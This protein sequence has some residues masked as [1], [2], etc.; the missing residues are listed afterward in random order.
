MTWGGG[1]VSET[2]HPSF[3]IC[4]AQRLARSY[5]THPASQSHSHLQAAWYMH[6][7]RTW[8]WSAG[9][10]QP[11]TWLSFKLQCLLVPL[12]RLTYAPSS[13]HLHMWKPC[14]MELSSEVHN[15]GDTYLKQTSSPG[16]GD[17]CFNIEGRL[18]GLQSPVN[19]T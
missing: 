18:H 12:T 8:G 13:C 11:T 7:A 19:L 4:S 2:R 6:S 16:R 3:W 15:A 17:V 14:P 1:G 10:P 9:L 5:P